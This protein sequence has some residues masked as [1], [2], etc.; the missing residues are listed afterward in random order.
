MKNVVFFAIMLLVM[1][2]AFSQTRQEVN[3]DFRVWRALKS[4]VKAGRNMDPYRGISSPTCF[5][6][7]RMNHSN[8]DSLQGVI[9]TMNYSSH[10][11]MA[12][13]GYLQNCTN[14][15]G[16]AMRWCFTSDSLLNLWKPDTSKAPEK[17]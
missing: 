11:W 4:V 12:V 10:H 8:L 7:M 6:M 14:C 9:Q 17:E 13:F 16:T 1:T 15:S 2:I 3:Y 5:N